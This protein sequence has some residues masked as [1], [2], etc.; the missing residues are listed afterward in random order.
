MMNS[1]P[2]RPLTGRRVTLWFV[3]FFGVVIAVNFFMARQATATFGGVVVNNSYVAS[4]NFN[5][6]LDAAETQRGLGWSAEATRLPDGRIEVR[7]AGTGAAQLALEGEAR[8]PLGRQPDRHIGFQP[9][10]AARFVSRE[11][12]PEGRWRL[13]LKAD[14]GEA[15]W[16]GEL[17]LQ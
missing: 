15:N 3:A 11:A 12:L 7:F 8:H 4:Q 17:A 2:I 5:R 14:A 9:A 16:R 13:R 10:G 6:W 1:K